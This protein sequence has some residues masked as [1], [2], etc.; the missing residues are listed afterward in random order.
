MDGWTSYFPSRRKTGKSNEGTNPLVL[1]LIGIEVADSLEQSVIPPLFQVKANTADISSL[2]TRAL[3]V[4]SCSR[5][6]SIVSLLSRITQDTIHTTRYRR[7]ALWKVLLTHLPGMWH[8]LTQHTPAQRCVTD[9]SQIWSL[10]GHCGLKLELPFLF[11]SLW[12]KK[13][14]GVFYVSR[15]IPLK[16][17]NVKPR[18]HSMCNTITLTLNLVTI[19]T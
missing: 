7:A 16:S 13:G 6:L 5:I 19:K 15:G 12:V 18:G 8:T 10:K 1:F 2:S 3:Y 14:K 9:R 17:S 4:L 11:K